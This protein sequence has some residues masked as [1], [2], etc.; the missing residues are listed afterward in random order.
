MPSR[1]RKGM[2]GA[3]ICLLA[4]TAVGL[5]FY[6]QSLT[7]KLSTHNPTS[8]WRYLASWLSGVYICALA[9]PVIFRLS[10]RFP[11]E[12][13]NW[14]RRVP[15]HLVTNAVIAVGEIALQ[16]VFINDFHL[17]PAV[18]S[19]FGDTFGI[20]MRSAFHQNF[21]SCWII[22]GVEH[23]LRYYHGYQERQQAA[24]RLELQAS[25]LKT[26]LVR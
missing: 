24:L 25:E 1:L 2:R 26:Q 16:G 9:T 5:F 11:I 21:M 6:T 19:R 20:L 8:W 13:S 18:M 15:L 10:R 7:Q 23:G 17:F 22:L 14:A 4:W 12:R 3:A